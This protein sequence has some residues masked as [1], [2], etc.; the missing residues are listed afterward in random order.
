[1]TATASQ[2]PATLA[3][4][5]VDVEDLV[6]Y[7]TNPRR[8]NLQVIA[9]SLR[10][11][12]QYRPIV[13]RKDTNE[14]LAGNHTLLAARDLGWTRIAATYVDC[15]DDT[16]AK[17]V[18]V[19][20]RANDLA[21]Y[22]DRLLAELLREVETDLTG[23][24]Y[25]PADLAALLAE[26]DGDPES[27]TDVDDI[28][29]LEPEPH[30]RTGDVWLLGPHRLAVGDS[31]D[32]AVVG[33]ACAGAQA[34]LVVTDPP[35]NVAYTGKTRDALTIENDA[36]SPEDFRRFLVDAYAAMF[37]HTG[38]GCPIYVFYA[39]AEEINFR[40]ALTEAGWLYK[41]TL[42]WVKN[43]FVMSRQDYHWQHEPILYGW[44]PG[45]AHRWYGGFTPTTLAAD[46]QPDPRTLSKAQLL[47]LVE[48]F[49]AQTT[50]L[51]EDRPARNAEHP[52]AK[53]VALLSRLID[54]SSRH[55]E[56]VLDPFAGSGA[57]L[58]A[59]HHTRRT[60][61]LVELDPRYADVICKRYEAHTGIT[62]VREADGKPHVFT[63]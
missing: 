56:L 17:I 52:T 36:M 38:K 34:S 3:G 13:V 43:H 45:A 57:T 2:I 39:T 26:L 4:L 59:A 10:T 48:G 60:A 41:Q 32:P 12:G 15:D 23:T 44:R 49:Y 30:T 53:P 5:E 11:H 42:L 33:A 61:A 7:R 51:R 31:R 21:G 18:L 27:R 28:P 19:D 24:G 63:E 6:P 35:Y 9:E 37:E 14:V 46:D 29:L 50:A 58:I 1:M 47:E 16:A 22:D 20:N 54:N 62:P 25:E 8:G 55:G 40:T